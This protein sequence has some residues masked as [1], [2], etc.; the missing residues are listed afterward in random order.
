MKLRNFLVMLFLLGGAV[1]FAA[2]E[3][4]MG[5]AG[6]KGDKGDKGDPG[7][8]G[9][10]GK[11]GAKG[12]PGEDLT[13]TIDPRCDVSNGITVPKNF[14][15]SPVG[16][17][18]DDIICGNSISDDIKAG[19]G[20]D[21]VYGAGGNDLLYGEK[22]DDTL[23]GEEGEDF[24]IGGEGDDTAYGGE[25]QDYFQ[26]AG[27]GNDEFYGGEDDDAFYLG[28]PGD[29]TFDGGP[30]LDRINWAIPPDPGNIS[31]PNSNFLTENSTIDLSSGTFTHATY[32]NKKL[33]SI[34]DVTGG[35]GNDRI[36]GDNEDNFLI[37]W[38]GTDTLIGGGGD[39]TLEPGPGPGAAGKAD[40]GDGNDTLIVYGGT[41]Q[42]PSWSSPY[43]PGGTNAKDTFILGTTLAG[44][45]TNFENLSALSYDYGFRTSAVTFTGDGK[46]NILTGGSGADVLNGAGGNDI[47]IGSKG[48]D[49][50]TGGTGND[51]FVIVKEDGDTV[52]VDIITDFTLTDDKIYF[53]GFAAG[54]RALTN[55]AG[56]ISVGGV[57]VVQ[58]GST[59]DNTKAG[60]IIS[61]NKYEFVVADWWRRPS[62]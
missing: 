12:N 39:D 1:F 60:N 4:D 11:D 54:A 46:A 32:G 42:L 18:D 16:T 24:L 23:Y 33:V 29:D 40:G 51:T 22:G 27:E 58:I 34:E 48:V 10:A 31:V 62:R 9:R 17:N 50:L 13:P 36:T 59:A 3:G 57:E 14:A 7:P 61:Q 8:A 41:Y 6:P 15:V 53:S 19:E 30:G 47:L 45:M 38:N 49:N 56:K 55:T 52:G 5:P 26:G 43:T 37:G 25:G 44:D 28:Q 35:R 2:C 20:D 21:T